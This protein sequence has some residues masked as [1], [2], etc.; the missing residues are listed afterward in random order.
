MQRSIPIHHCELAI[1]ESRPHIISMIAVPLIRSFY[2]PSTVPNAASRR[3]DH[4]AVMPIVVGATFAFH[5]TDIDII[6]TTLLSLLSSDDLA[7]CTYR[8]HSYP[9]QSC[10]SMMLPS[11]S[12]ATSGVTFEID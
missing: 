4:A 8:N 9:T 10:V 5:Y 1:H 12:Q 7:G 2:R 3:G 6:T 11:R